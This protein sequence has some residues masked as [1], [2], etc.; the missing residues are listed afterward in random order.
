VSRP[1]GERP[2]Y[3]VQFRASAK[4]D[5]AAL[6]TDVRFGV[7]K[8][9]FGPPKT[10]ATQTM[11]SNGGA[12]WLGWIW[13]YEWWVD[14]PTNCSAGMF[15]RGRVEKLDLVFQET[16]GSTNANGDVWTLNSWSWREN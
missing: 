5:I 8:K 9:I 3:T 16:G 1:P 13:T 4:K 7:K 12:P 2:K 6:P 10:I 11:G 14:H 15:C